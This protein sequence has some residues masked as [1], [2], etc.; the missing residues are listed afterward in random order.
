MRVV[1]TGLFDEVEVPTLNLTAKHGE[2]VEVGDHAGEQLCQQSCWE[3]VK[4]GG[5]PGPT[6]EA[7]LGR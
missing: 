7:A 6:S 3:Q 4:T 1:Y 5:K 2:P